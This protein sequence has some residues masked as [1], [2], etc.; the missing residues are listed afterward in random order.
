ML[1]QGV[2]CVP[3]AVVET[4][5]EM[6]Q[7]LIVELSRSAQSYSELCGR[8]NPLFVDVYIAMIEMGINVQGLVNFGRRKTKYHIQTPQIQPKQPMPKIL[9]V[10]DKRP[11]L[12]YIPDYFPSFPGGSPV[13]VSIETLAIAKVFF[14][15]AIFMWPELSKLILLISACSEA[16]QI[17]RSSH[18]WTNSIRS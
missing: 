13:E 12:P 8:S 14:S 16:L 2:Q 4:L 18:H 10:G 6:V 15:R 17:I 3:N 9:Q 1:E 11:L 5:V 7:S